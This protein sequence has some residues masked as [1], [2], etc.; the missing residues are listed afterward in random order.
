MKPEIVVWLVRDTCRLSDNP[1]LRRASTLAKSIGARL[2]PLACLEPRRWADQQFGLP[3]VGEHWARFRAESLQSLRND[4]SARGCGLWISAEEPVRALMRA[5]QACH[6]FT[7]I[8]DVPLGTEERLET[9]RIQAEDFQSEVVYSDELFRFE[10]LPFD[11]IDLPAT[12][13]KF[14]KVVEKKPGIF[15]DPPQSIPELSPSLAQP[16]SDPSEWLESLRSQISPETEVRTSGGEASALEHWQAYLDTGALSHYRLT[17][18]ALCGPTQSS[19]LSAWLAHGCISARQIWSDILDYERRAGANES[20]YWL[21]FELLWREFFRWYSRACDWTLFRRSGPNDKD[22]EGDQNR[23]RFVAWSTGNTGC[24]IVDAAMRELNQ[25]GW[26][27]NRARQLVASHLVYESNL[28]WRLG[29]AYFES[30][31]VDFDVASNWG[32]WAYI[33][34]VGPDPRGGRIFN[35][36]DQAGRYDPDKNYRR[37]WLQ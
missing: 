37:R 36:N 1:A 24:D 10:Q 4:L 6:V 21:R 23:R 14:R 27:S 13:S 2:V 31:L 26:M 3:R 16:W 8:S 29:A 34:G 15:P 20:T 18:N 35:L 33:A 25:T 12:F 19:H 28:D 5:R 11:L 17:R 30:R 32:N 22:A 9:E 7:V